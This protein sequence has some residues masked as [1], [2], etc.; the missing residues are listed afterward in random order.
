MSSPSSHVVN[1]EWHTPVRAKVH[2]YYHDFHLSKK[3]IAED[4]DMDRHVVQD[5]LSKPVRRQINFRGRNKTIDPDEVQK[6]IQKVFENYTTRIF[7][8]EGLGAACDI[9]AS[10]RTIRRTMHEAGFYKCKACHHPFI[11]AVGATKRVFWVDTDHRDEQPLEYWFDWHFSDEV[12]LTTGMQATKMVIRTMGDRHNP[13]C[14]SNQFRSGRASFSCWGSVGWFWKS[15]LIFLEGHGK[16]D[17]FTQEDYAEQVIDAVVGPYFAKTMKLT[18]ATPILYEDGNSAHGLAGTKPHNP[19]SKT[20]KRWNITYVASPPSSPDFNV[21]E[22]IWRIIKS[23]IKAY[24]RPITRLDELKE[25]V[26]KEWNRIEIGDIR[27]LILTMQDRM[28][29]AKERNGYATKY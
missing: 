8:W 10:A 5:L 6:M 12:T 21:I 2:T 16:R 26:Q 24:P 20:K 18:D 7:T 23:R 19:A 14:N 17:G 1:T 29:Q 3:R 9:H 11:S 15:P 28:K 27:K 4:L 22:N 25:A 13:D